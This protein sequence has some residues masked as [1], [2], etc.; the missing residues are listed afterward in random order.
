MTQARAH[1]TRSA[2]LLAA[3]RVFERRGFAAAAISEI[4]A[5]AQVTKGALYFH[6]DS[7]ESL[8]TAIVE[9][10]SNW[11][12]AN[13]AE[14]TCPIQRLID[15][16][17]RF[18]DALRMDP[19]VRASI[20]LTIER[21]TFATDDPGPYQGWVEALAA[22]LAEAAESEDL[23]PDLDPDDVASLIAGCVTGTQLLSEAMTGRSDLRSRLTTMWRHLLPGIV[24]ERVLEDLVVDGTAAARLAR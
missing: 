10:Q 5:E 23:L 14:S 18:A 3:A 7:K 2:V 13:T 24:P 22:M 9:E 12:L 17:H 11:R 16:S 21:N 6:F 19:L 4:L 15:L 20:R 1:A 8:A